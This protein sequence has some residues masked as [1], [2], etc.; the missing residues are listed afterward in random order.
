MFFSKLKNFR[1]MVLSIS[2]LLV[3]CNDFKYKIPLSFDR[4][5]D[6][7]ANIPLDVTNPD[8]LSRDVQSGSHYNHEISRDDVEKYFKDAD[9]STLEITEGPN[10][11]S[12]EFDRPRNQASFSGSIPELQASEMPK[13]IVVKGVI[14]DLEGADHNWEFPLVIKEDTSPVIYT[15]DIL[16]SL[17]SEFRFN[18]TEEMISDLTQAEVDN[19]QYEITVM[20]KPDWLEKENQN[21]LLGIVPHVGFN[22]AVISGFIHDSTGNKSE[23]SFNLLAPST[24]LSVS[25]HIT[26][27]GSPFSDQISLRKDGVPD[28]TE[29]RL[30]DVELYVTNLPCWLGYTYD[31]AN[32]TITFSGVPTDDDLGDNIVAGVVV[33]GYNVSSGWSFEVHVM[34]DIAPTISSL[35]IDGTTPSRN[36]TPTLLVGL[37]RSNKNTVVKIHSDPSCEIDIG[38][39][40]LDDVKKQ[41]S[42]TIESRLSEGNH[43]LYASATDLSNK[44]IS[45]YELPEPYVVDLN[46]PVVSG[47]VI[48]T[49][50]QKNNDKNPNLTVHF[51]GADRGSVVKIF[52]KNQCVN[53]IAQTRLE[54]STDKIDIKLN[55]LQDGV[56][57][58]YARVID[59]AGN[60][61]SC[62]KT[63]GPYR[64]D[65][66]APSILSAALLDTTPNTGK[67]PTFKVTL[68]SSSGSHVKLFSD[69]ACRNELGIA[70]VGG[71]TTA[72]VLVDKELNDGTHTIYAQA[73]DSA[74][75]ASSCTPGDRPYVVDTFEPA[76]SITGLSDSYTPT[77]V[78]TF[79]WTGCGEYRY[80]VTSGRALDDSVVWS[81][82]STQSSAQVDGLQNVD[83]TYYL[84]IQGRNVDELGNVSEISSSVASTHIDAKK[85]EVLGLRDDSITQVQNRTWSWR[86]DERNCVYRYEITTSPT[87]PSMTHKYSG[88]T[89]VSKNCGEGTYYLHVQAK[90]LAGNESLVVTKKVEM[91]RNDD[92]DDTCR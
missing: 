41:A 87:A 76:C 57:T 81:R 56:H 42:I 10:W 21:S 47:L 24:S 29:D 8:M 34:E 28:I 13:T 17:G 44:N 58:F 67:T 6:D 38:T 72:D 11:L 39:L 79:N 4:L 12:Y 89:S 86:C 37:E 18:F 82:W 20:E 9:L 19:E 43:N 54:D 64:L 15:R 51:N 65:T 59:F 60:E 55:D 46:K 25:D 33:N 84:H 36:Q 71:I 23:W 69:E 83:D 68:L 78:K 22:G 48:E 77:K 1:F 3:S 14:E 16:L 80:I 61:S 74:G 53:P 2:F 49:L 62:I 52:D 85:P 66:E 90:D 91:T 26:E 35:S 88:V 92:L 27:A 30:S 7:T 75:N 5:D 32:K 31:Y 40:L 70:S 45:C 73:Y 63:P 50:E